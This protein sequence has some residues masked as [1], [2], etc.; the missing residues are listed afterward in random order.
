MVD[1]G[2]LGASFISSSALSAQEKKQI[3]QFP[4]EVTVESVGGDVSP[5][6]WIMKKICNPDTGATATVKFTVL[7]N[8]PTYKCLIRTE[9]A[10]KVG[11]CRSIT[12][13]SSYDVMDYEYEVEYEEFV[14][15]QSSYLGRYKNYEYH[16]EVV[17]PPG[18]RPIY[19]PN[20]ENCWQMI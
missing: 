5:L 9:D 12:F 10:H 16:F 13:S 2:A 3:R 18:H 17:L 14:P 6:G 1:T 15:L 19:V 8:I 20:R 4:G 11:E 7:E